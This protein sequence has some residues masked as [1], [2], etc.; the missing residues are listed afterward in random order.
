M[1]KN[2]N[3]D[4]K[5]K[6]VYENKINNI[7]YTNQDIKLKLNKNS[8]SF[9]N[10]KTDLKKKDNLFIKTDF[11]HN[12]IKKYH[13]N[14]EKKIKLTKNKSI[15]DDL[16][17]KNN[18]KLFKNNLS[19]SSKNTLNIKIYLSGN[20]NRRKFVK[21]K[22]QKYLTHLNIPKENICLNTNRSLDIKKPYLISSRVNTQRKSKDTK[23]NKQKKSINLD[24]EKNN[25]KKLEN[26]SINIPE[27]ILKLDDIKS[28][29]YKLLNIYSLIALKSI[30]DSNA[31]PNVNDI[32]K[33]KDKKERK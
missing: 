11:K 17:Y 7:I 31:I 1:V 24:L 4:I 10:L 29:I 9:T 5:N 2:N 12:L 8:K 28:R 33:V 19:K 21:K 22:S 27:Y 14:S 16:D 23:N 30:N 26:K 6:K 25:K 18:L 13:S 32:E 20:N 15:S 3:T